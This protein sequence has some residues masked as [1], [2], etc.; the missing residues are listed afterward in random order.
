MKK[1]FLITIDTEGDN[2]WDLDKGISTE[3]VKYLPRFQ[4]LAEQYGFKPVWLT[5]YEMATNA[6]FIQYM[7]NK[8]NKGLCEIGMHLHAW[9]SPPE[10]K[11]NK[12]N[13]ERD[14]LIEYPDDIM[15]E[16]IKNL[17]DIITKNF[18]E[19]PISH[20][21]GRWTTNHKYF[22]ILKKYGYQVDCSITPHVNWK[23]C[24]GSTGVKGSDYSKCP[25]HPYLLHEQILEVPMTIRKIR[26]FQKKRIKNFTSFCKEIYRLITG[27]VQWMRPDTHS[28]LTSYV[29]II[30]KCS[31]K[32][33]Y[34]M[35]MIHSSELMSGGSPTFKTNQEIEKLYVIIEGIFE[36]AKS[37][38]YI[39]MTLREYQN[40]LKKIDSKY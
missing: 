15:D 10:Y 28:S 18:G 14:Y 8:Q 19:K 26:R 31:K 2:Q 21:S 20:R 16:K 12:I 36:Y 17:T 39:G 35:F 32:N 4:D 11:L 33:E 34:V 38:G 29:N 7:K 27:R 37:Q 40:Y 25:E 6:D 22:E 24:L 30:K 9:N 3:N 13:K 23:R 5:N 1:V